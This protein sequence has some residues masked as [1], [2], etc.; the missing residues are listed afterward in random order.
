MKIIAI[1]VA[2][3]ALS[4]CSVSLSTWGPIATQVGKAA[5]CES[6][7]AEARAQIRE[8]FALPHVVQCP[9]D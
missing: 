8:T 7:T 6:K 4:G 5:Y 9:D 3:L 2:A 1:G